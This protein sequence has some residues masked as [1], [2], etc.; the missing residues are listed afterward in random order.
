MMNGPSFFE[1][2]ADDLQRALNFYKEIFG[3][4]FTKVEGLP[5]E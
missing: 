2:Q 4:K 1:I 3:W 5:V